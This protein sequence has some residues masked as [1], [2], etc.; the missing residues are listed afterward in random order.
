MDESILFRGSCACQRV[1][2]TCTSPP[3]YLCNCHCVT[4]RKM[5]GAPYCTF[6]SFP[7][8]AVTWIGKFEIYRKSD[9]AS[10]AF[11]Q[12]CSS[13]LFMQYNHE[14]SA[15]DSSSPEIGICAGLIDQGQETL[16][17]PRNHIF[18]R[19]KAPWFVVP[20]DGAQRFQEFDSDD[21]QSLISDGK[22]PKEPEL[23]RTGH[24]VLTRD[25]DQFDSWTS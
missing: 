17:K 3:T 14:S 13:F 20:D 16:P 24:Q 5:A 22:L 18:L 25:A 2:L 23:D 10:R 12:K 15:A 21:F 4:C 19:E 9:V 6:A 1:K 11:C 8:R 7:E